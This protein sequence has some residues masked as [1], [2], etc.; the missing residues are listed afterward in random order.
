MPNL[1]KISFQE[2][3]VD[4]ALF[5]LAF[6]GLSAFIR[7]PSIVLVDLL[8]FGNSITL[9]FGICTS[10]PQ[11]RRSVLCWLLLVATYCV[12]DQEENWIKEP[13]SIISPIWVIKFLPL[14]YK[15]DYTTD[16]RNP[17]LLGLG[18]QFEQI[19]FW[20]YGVFSANLSAPILVLWVHF[21]HWS[22][23]STKTKPLYP[24]FIEIFLEIMENFLKFFFQNLS[25]HC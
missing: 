3:P 13:E 2:K 16:H 24:A 4:I 9:S 6:L 18:R 21:F 19:N 5:I 12:P 10:R 8:G 22:T 25:V 7:L 14:G 23:I 20:T 15:I 11:I 17:K 1:S